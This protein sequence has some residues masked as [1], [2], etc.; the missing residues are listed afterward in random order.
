MSRI[1]KEI[2]EKSASVRQLTFTPHI[3]GTVN[4]ATGSK[5][6]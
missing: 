3:I 5:Q 1:E 4:T 2:K 6:L